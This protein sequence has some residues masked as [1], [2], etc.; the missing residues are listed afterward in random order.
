MRKILFELLI[1]L[2]IL[3]LNPQKLLAQ[4]N[5]DYRSIS[6]GAWSDSSNW[7][8]YVGNTWMPANS[9]PN[10]SS[11][12][13]TIRNG[14]LITI[15]FDVTVD[16]T[17]IES[18]GDFGVNVG[19]TLTINDGPGDDF[20]IQGGNLG[21][22]GNLIVNNGARMAGNGS[23]GYGAQLL[24]N[25]G[26]IDLAYI[27]YFGSSDNQTIAGNG[28]IKQ[29]IT[30]NNTYGIYLGGDQTFTYAL[31]FNYGGLHT[32]PHTA[33]LAEFASVQDNS[34]NSTFVD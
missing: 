13:T 14:H 21:I 16:E 24:V 4:S 22:S 8:S 32:G 3:S 20:T 1:T 33:I 2:S 5:G 6:S 26:T 9:S 29:L 12:A 11:G 31:N 27:T 34:G 18:G 15:A 7:E 30:F 17:I 23:L 25:N 28:T 10:F 19:T